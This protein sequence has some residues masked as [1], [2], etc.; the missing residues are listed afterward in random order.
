MG[1]SR[2]RRFLLAGA[3]LVA[4]TLVSTCGSIG[5]GGANPKI[6]SYN[7][8]PVVGGMGG[9]TL[10]VI[11]LDAILTAGATAVDHP[12]LTI[13]VVDRIGNILRV[14][15]RTPSGVV[16]GGEALDV[17]NKFAVA[18]ARAAAYLSHSQAPLTSRTGQ[19]LSTFHFPGVFDDSTFSTV[20]PATFLG[21][22]IPVNPTLGVV[23]T[24]QAPLWQ[25][26]AS[27]RGGMDQ[28]LFNMG[29][30]IPILTNPDGSQAT[31]GLGPVP[32][33]LPLY[34]TPAAAPPAP[35]KTDV[36]KRLVGGVGVYAWDTDPTMDPRPDIMEFTAWRA[37]SALSATT[38]DPHYRFV[39]DIPFEGAVYLVGILLP[40]VDPP[41]QPA[42]TAPGAY[43]PFDI[44]CDGTGA[45]C[46]DML[47]GETD[48][49][50][51]LVGP[52]DSTTPSLAMGGLSGAEVM[53][54]LDGCRV[55][56]EQT[57]AAIRLPSDAQCKMIISVSDLDGNILGVYREEDATLFSLEI[58]VSKARNAV[59]LS[60]PASR[61]MDPDAPFLL[62]GVTST[63]G[64]HP[65]F[66]VF[67][68]PDLGDVGGFA[69]MTSTGVAVTGR[70]LGFLSQ[71]HYPP[72][73]D[74]SGIVGPFYSLANINRDPDY[75][76][77]Q[78]YESD[79]GLGCTQRS[80]IIFFPGSAP[81]YRDG[82]LIG[83]I[84]V[85]GDGVEQDDYVTFTGIQNAEAVLGFDLEPPAS[86]RIDNFEYAGVKIPY[87]KFPQQPEG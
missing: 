26:D 78:G 10:Q 56:S 30:A 41:I 72:T 33:A 50:L 73:I 69:A 17:E 9:D 75:F 43:D 79:P 49:E 5:G 13:A 22:T 51:F 53:E 63:V 74:G 46:V 39:E 12:N 71:P 57:H 87:F 60:N 7:F 11:D 42:G 3:S 85:S 20:A 55:A 67:A 15:N 68:E 31:P 59:F 48:P 25:I 86:I 37:S 66:P 4:A 62:D 82:V 83:G 19:F 70:S 52:L 29:M 61:N 28:L 65:L 23:N 24:P 16:F 27:N 35:A 44:V 18:L 21:Q 84:G 54:I 58:S 81:L 40:Y 76:D 77:C 34:K 14:Y 36:T 80:G 6:T 38:G 47:F 64:E 45:V 32:G 1:G 8:I 2:T